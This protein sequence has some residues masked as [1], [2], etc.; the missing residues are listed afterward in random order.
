MVSLVKVSHCSKT[1]IIDGTQLADPDPQ[2]RLN[3]RDL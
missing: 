2:N 3:L 1:F